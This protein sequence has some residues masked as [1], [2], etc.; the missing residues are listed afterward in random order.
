[1]T[2]RAIGGLLVLNVFILGVGAG[3]LWGLRGWR[4]WT[5]FARLVGVAYFLGFSA[6]TVLMMWGIVVG[7]PIE[8][9]TILVSGGA[10][11]VGG[12]LVGRRR[13]FTAPGLR[14]PGWRFPGISVFGALFVAGIVVYFEALFRADRL[15]GVA[16]EWDSWANWLPK[17]KSLYASGRVD[18]EFLALVP[19]LPSYPPGPASIQAASFH[20]MGSADTVTL[21]VQYWF[22]AVVLRPRGDRPARAPR[23]PRDPAPGAAGSPRRALSPGLADHRLRG[24][25]DGLSDRPRGAPGHPVDR[26]E[27]ALAARHGDP[28]PVRGDADETRGDALRGLRAARRLRRVVRGSASAVAAVVRGGARRRRARAAV[29]DLVHRPRPLGGR[30]RHGVRRRLLT[31]RP[32]VARSGDQPQDAVPSRS[33]AFR[34]GP[35][36]GGHRPCPARRGL[37]GLPVRE[38]LPGRRVRGRDLGALVQPRALARPLGLGHPPPHGD[39]GPRARGADASPAAAG[40]VVGPV[41]ASDRQAAR[42]GRALPAVAGRVG[43]RARRAALASRLGT[44]RLLRQRS[45]G[46]LAQ[47]PGHRRLR[48]AS[49]HRRERPARRRLRRLVPGGDGPARARAGGGAGGRRGEP[50]RLRTSPRLRRRPTDDGKQLSLCWSRRRPRA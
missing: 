20:A 15:A 45:A 27:E 18:L 19:Q 29:E 32:A 36:G 11:A 47:L 50:G 17:S 21:H 42:P 4:W 49:R 30:V 6:L 28:A 24:H 40:V 44:R 37:E 16:R 22:L 1:M 35:G 8:P 3:V 7:I 34:S 13:G 46:R 2:L 43:N 5:D 14:P 26:G 38:R 9:T 25:P 41:L 48:R 33:V 39:D 10:L 23:A 31:S 12:A